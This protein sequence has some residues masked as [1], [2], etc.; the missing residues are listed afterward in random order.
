MLP[1]DA[2]WEARCRRCGRCCYEKVEYAGEVFYTDTPCEHLDPATR[3][4][5][6]YPR[7]HRARP[8]CAPL[9]PE[10]IRQG[11]LPADCPYVEGIPGYR[12]PHLRD[13]DRL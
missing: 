4:C 13:E 8:G 3:L 5:A 12:A 1:R 2:A 10:N 9:T 11:I 6:V 7:R